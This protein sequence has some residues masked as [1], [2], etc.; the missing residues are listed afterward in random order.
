VEVLSEALASSRKLAEVLKNLT[1]V[2]A[3]VS[4]LAISGS[5]KV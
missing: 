4:G 2:L 5:A 3:E 1:E